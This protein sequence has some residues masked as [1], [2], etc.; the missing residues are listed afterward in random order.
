MCSHVY[1][2]MQ[3]IS[4]SFI[5]NNLQCFDTVGWVA[6]TAAGL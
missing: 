3:T 2:K 5:L 1:A 4:Y 6:V